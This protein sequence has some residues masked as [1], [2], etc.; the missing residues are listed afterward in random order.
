MRSAYGQSVIGYVEQQR[1]DNFT[2]NVEVAK[3]LTAAAA[4]AINVF[5]YL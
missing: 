1:N 5:V 3:R 4:A 2:R